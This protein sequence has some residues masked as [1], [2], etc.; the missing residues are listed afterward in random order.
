MPRDPLAGLE[1]QVVELPFTEGLANKFTTHF[2]A[3]PQD[4]LLQIN[5]AE[6]TEIGKFRNRDGFVSLSN[7]RVGTEAGAATIAGTHMKLFQR[8]GELGCIANTQISLGSGAGWGGA[9]DTVFSFTPS[10]TPSGAWKAHGKIA[11]P[12]LSNLGNITPD[13]NIRLSD[14]AVAGNFAIVAWHSVAQA[15]NPYGNIFWRVFDIT[16]GTTVID[17]TEFPLLGTHIAA[18]TVTS[19]PAIGANAA[20]FGVGTGHQA[21]LQ[22]LAIGTRLYVFVMAAASNAAA[23]SNDVLGFYVDMGV[24]NP[25]PS[26]A[27]NIS[28]SVTSYSVCTDGT[29]I[30]LVYAAPVAPLDLHAIKFNSALGSVT[31]VTTTIGAPE[32]AIDDL[33]CSANFGVLAVTY[34]THTS[35]SALYHQSAI[36]YAT[37]ALTIVGTAL[38]FVEYV[39][40]GG[41]STDWALNLALFRP[42]I[43]A[44]T[45]VDFVVCVSGD[46]GSEIIGTQGTVF[47]WSLLKIVAGAL[48]NVTATGAGSFFNFVAQGISNIAKMFV[49]NGRVFVPAVKTDI[50][51]ASGQNCDA[52]YFLLE[53][54]A[55]ATQGATDLYRLPMIA[56]AWAPDISAPVLD[57]NTIASYLPLEYGPKMVLTGTMSAITLISTSANSGVV[58]PVPI[59]VQVTTAGALGTWIGAVSYDDITTVSQVFTSST[60]SPQALTGPGEGFSLSFTAGVTAVGDKAVAS[61]RSSRQIALANGCVSGNKYYIATRSG[62]QFGNSPTPLFSN[63]VL[64]AITLDFADNYRWLSKAAGALTVFSGAAPYAFDGRRAFEA[65]IPCRPR[66]AR[67]L[68]STTDVDLTTHVI[69]AGVDYFFRAV[70]TWLDANG[71][72]WF[73]APSYASRKG[74]A[75][76]ARTTGRYS[77]NMVFSGTSFAPNGTTISITGTLTGGPVPIDVTVTAPGQLG[78]WTYAISYDNGASQSMTGTSPGGGSLALT[79]AGAGLTLGFTN[80]WAGADNVWRVAAKKLTLLVTLPPAFSGMVNGADFFKNAT[81]VWLY[82]STA[83]LPTVQFLIAQVKADG[84]AAAQYTPFALSPVV[85]VTLNDEPAVS[86]DQIYTAGGELE[87]S[88][89]PACRVLE[90]HRDRIFAISSYDNNVYYTKTHTKGRGLEWCQQTQLIP[91]A[92]QGLGL[93]SNETCLMIFT[94]RAVYAVEGYGPSATGQPAQ[95]FGALQL[96]SN[97]LGLYEVNSC[98]ATPIGVIFRTSQGWWLVDRTLSVS[99]IGENTDVISTLDQTLAL[100][101]D[102]RLACVRLMMVPGGI[103]SNGYKTYN[104]WF[105]SKRW[106]TDTHGSARNVVHKDAMVLGDTYFVID[107]NDVL[108]R[109]GVIYGTSW[110]DGQYDGSGHG[111]SVSTGWITVANMAMYK[112][113][114]RVIA[115]VENLSNGNALNPGLNLVVYAD[116]SDSAILVKTFTSDMIGTGV[117]T[118]RAHLPKQKMK[119]IKIVLQQTILSGTLADNN[120]PGYN[121]IGFGF[122]IGLKNRT[123]PEPAARST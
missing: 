2:R 30:F 102:Q 79:G 51:P 45:S 16:T 32:V 104:Y 122:E 10:I 85:S 82:M 91:I 29:S 97:Q 59:R 115:T 21:K 13:S 53:L 100:N 77:G 56:A 34:L 33:N 114:W 27:V 75:F 95:A 7:V 60:A 8:A 98:K 57:T 48:T 62:A 38:S 17:T 110:V 92:E 94:N 76:V 120:N 1:K 118:I 63:Y 81:E 25:A 23:A 70:Y 83:A 105:D 5:N 99:F 39:G 46:Q 52:G 20:R 31:G 64:E 11:R 108:A 80:G 50:F 116:W 61:L 90:A 84:S 87:N 86:N 24:A 65:G 123:S 14:M 112:R 42:D 9:G 26:A 40:I 117:Q 4:A 121:F 43:V 106:S 74:D 55:S 89:A 68:A 36:V 44:L 6:L 103:G 54:N 71:D 88:P 66:I 113:I 49:M 96:I 73:S 35:G 78:I 18:R 12:T 3:T 101:V 58:L 107:A 47:R 72:R 119:A 111:P 93:A 28:N 41:V 109:Q 67:A 22:C 37:A 69:K 19:V 15:D